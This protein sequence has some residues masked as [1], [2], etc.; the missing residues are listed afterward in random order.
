MA[1]TIQ[2]SKELQMTLSKRK[3]ADTDTY[4][5]I[6]WDLVEDTLELN[7]RTKKDIEKSRAEIRAGKFYTH[8]EV[9]KKLGL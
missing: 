7:E 9:K 3:L 6:I 5:E 1:T 4:E 2:I 8:S